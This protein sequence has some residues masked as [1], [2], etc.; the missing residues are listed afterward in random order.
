M[1]FPPSSKHGMTIR[2]ASIRLTLMKSTI[3]LLLLATSCVIHAKEPKLMAKT[4]EQATTMEN[5]KSVVDWKKP[6]H[7]VS[8]LFPCFDKA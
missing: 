5:L 2:L 4:V 6:A 8:V 7:G 1:K 3:G